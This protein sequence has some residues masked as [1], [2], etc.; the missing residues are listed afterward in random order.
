LIL[1]H[2]IAREG[3]TTQEFDDMLAMLADPC[4][5]PPHVGNLRRTYRLL[6]GDLVILR[7]DPADGEPVPSL[8]RLPYALAVAS[9]RL[10]ITQTGPGVHV[11]TFRLEQDDID[12]F[13]WLLPSKPMEQMSFLRDLLGPPDGPALVIR[14][15]QLELEEIWTM[16]T[17]FRISGEL[18]DTITD[19]VER[20]DNEDEPPVS[21]SSDEED[22]AAL[23]AQRERDVAHVSR[24]LARS[25]RSRAPSQ[26]L[27]DYLSGL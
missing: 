23:Q 7:A 27:I 10:K 5:A 15:D 21:E 18:H 19:C 12:G 1:R 3:A 26:S 6:P 20:L 14:A 25:Q 17:V 2:E 24:G 11:H 4:E 22:E 9:R 16:G 8:P 13:E